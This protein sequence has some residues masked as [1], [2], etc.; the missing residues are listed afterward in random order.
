MLK[1]KLGFGG[2]GKWLVAA[3]AIAPAAALLLVG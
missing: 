3:G 2:R 1:G